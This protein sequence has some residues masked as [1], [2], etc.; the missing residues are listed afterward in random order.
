LIVGVSVQGAR[1]ARGEFFLIK[2]K[3]GLLNRSDVHRGV[4]DV[5]HAPESRY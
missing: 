3:E 4:T 2:V 5:P 1:L